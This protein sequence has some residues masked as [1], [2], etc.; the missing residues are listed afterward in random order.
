M[1]NHRLNEIVAGLITLGALAAIVLTV[2][3]GSPPTH[4]P[5]HEAIGLAMARETLSLVQ[6]GSQITAHC[7]GTGSPL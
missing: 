6:P 3:E 7:G 2:A 1:R 5:L 4:R